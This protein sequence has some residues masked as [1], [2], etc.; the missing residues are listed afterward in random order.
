[1]ALLK[2]A[3]NALDPTPDRKKEITLTLNLLSELCENKA[4]DF[5]NKVKE[6]I[7]TAG[8]EENRT[9]PI[10][11]LIGVHKEYRAYVKKDNS[12]IPT[13][14]ATA[15]KGFINGGTDDIV[16]GIAS[17]VTTAIDAI[18]GKA[19]AIEQ[20]FE[21][22]YIDVQSFAIV[23]Y[24]ICGWSRQIEASG[25][26][27]H[28]ENCMAVY[29]SKGSVDVS[30]ISLNTF[31]LVYGSQLQKMKIPPTEI[32]T[33]LDKAEEIY[34]KLGGKGSDGKQLKVLEESTYRAMNFWKPGD[35]LFTPHIEEHLY[36]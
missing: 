4:S 10:T 34:Y 7:R 13:E 8:N 19:S 32:Q 27:K 16:N 36:Q 1:M 5:E 11:E 35:H 22:Y 26:T 28:I 33:Y 23:R 9:V 30:R 17:L 25:I 29:A 12:K 18:L 2:D 21:S 15:V 24:D 14:V 6:S 31:L 20:Q 3:I